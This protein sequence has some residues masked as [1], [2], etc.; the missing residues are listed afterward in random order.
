MEG[1]IGGHDALARG[2]ERALVVGIALRDARGV[3]AQV[4]AGRDERQRRGIDRIDLLRR[5]AIKLL[6]IVVGLPQGNEAHAANHQL[7]GE[8]YRDDSQ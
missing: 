2:L 4:R 3:A 8:K 7:E 5:Q 6:D 1:A